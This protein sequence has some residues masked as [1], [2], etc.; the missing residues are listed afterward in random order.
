MPY[1]NTVILIDD[2]NKLQFI[3]FKKCRII[4]NIHLDYIK[5]KYKN[6]KILNILPKEKAFRIFYDHVMG[7]NIEATK[8]L[9]N[10]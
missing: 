7:E 9:S 1:K 3:V 2:K 10:Q 4:R 6:S 8:E 5:E